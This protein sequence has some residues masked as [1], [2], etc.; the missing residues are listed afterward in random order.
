MTK[1]FIYSER[2]VARA[3]LVVLNLLFERDVV[4]D[5][6]GDNP[7]FCSTTKNSLSRTGGKNTTTFR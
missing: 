3:M 5:T 7:I 6:P 2:D 4:T 1:E